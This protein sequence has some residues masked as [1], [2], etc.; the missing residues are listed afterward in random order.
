MDNMP[1]LKQALWEVNKLYQTA[2]IYY[3]EDD[4]AKILNS[5]LFFAKK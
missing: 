4:V 2:R 3:F 1:K 5:F